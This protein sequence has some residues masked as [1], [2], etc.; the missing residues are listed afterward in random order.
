VPESG[1]PGSSAFDIAMKWLTGISLASSFLVGVWLGAV[2]NPLKE[3]DGCEESARFVIAWFAILFVAFSVATGLRIAGRVVTTCFLVGVLLGGPVLMLGSWL[4]WQFNPLKETDGW[5][6]ATDDE[7]RDG[8]LALQKG[9][10]RPPWEP[11]QFMYA[12]ELRQAAIDDVEVPVDGSCT[13]VTESLR[14]CVEPIRDSLWTRTINSSSASVEVLWQEALWIDETG[15]PHEV[16]LDEYGSRESR[17]VDP[18]EEY[19]KVAFPRGKMYLTTSGGT[20]YLHSEALIPWDQRSQHP[21][22]VRK[23]LV[24]ERRPFRFKSAIV[25]HGEKREVVFT[26]L[27]VPRSG[28]TS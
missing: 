12:V 21:D 26:Y 18:G 11:S 8:D 2:A 6:D 7:H 27:L 14:F 20:S 9:I 4:G 17:L 25:V 13:N 15:Q 24:S 19:R 28:G 10:Q 23:T 5:G 3:F 1:Q 16:V 22:E